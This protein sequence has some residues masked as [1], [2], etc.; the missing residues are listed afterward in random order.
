MRVYLVGSHSVGKSTLCRYISE[1]Y[2]L[3]M[4]YETAR[5][6]LAEMEVSLERLR[7]D[8]DLVGAYQYSVFEKQLAAEKEK[9]HFVSDRAFDFI[10][11]C[12]E[13]SLITQGLYNSKELQDYIEWV[14]GG[15][16]LFI[17]PQKSFLKAD[18]VRETP[19]WEGIVRIDGMIKLLL[20]TNGVSY[21]PIES[22]PMMERAR[23]V[24]FILS[25]ITS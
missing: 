3:P 23:T 15:V 16:V 2:K 1:K 18:G 10:A 17:R 20:E 9:Q 22:A 13:H 8:L 24:D 5:A 21:L 11:Y 6:A 19:V 25:K 12:A 14:R 7:T 4:I